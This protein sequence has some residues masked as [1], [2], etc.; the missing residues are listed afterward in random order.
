MVCQKSGTDHGAL[1][2][3]VPLGGVRTWGRRAQIGRG[4]LFVGREY[5]ISFKDRRRD[6]ED[7]DGR[8]HQSGLSLDIW[9]IAMKEAGPRR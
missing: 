1:L 2:F 4:P 9:A 8:S 6:V 7:A 3:F 5:P